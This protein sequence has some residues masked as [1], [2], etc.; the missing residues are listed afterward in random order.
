MSLRTKRFD[1]RAICG[2]SE[3][4]D[5]LHAWFEIAFD[6]PA[7]RDARRGMMDRPKSNIKGV[8]WKYGST[9]ML[10]KLTITGNKVSF[11]ATIKMLPHHEGVG[12]VTRWPA[13]E[14]S[15]GSCGRVSIW[16][17]GELVCELSLT[18]Q[19]C[20]SMNDHTSTSLFR[21][22]CSKDICNACDKY[23]RVCQDSSCTVCYLECNDVDETK[24]DHRGSWV[25]KV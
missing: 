6:C 4:G 23:A 16:L 14:Y 10:Y 13:L 21:C 2:P 18:L 20:D 12:K 19:I 15:C 22:R 7:G 25:V 17:L 8:R 3:I 1:S 11:K 24:Y 9:L 5:N